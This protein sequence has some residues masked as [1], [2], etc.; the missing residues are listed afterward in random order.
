M[1]DQNQILRLLGTIRE[2]CSEI[3]SRQEELYELL[4]SY[5]DQVHDLKRTVVDKLAGLPRSPYIAGQLVPAPDLTEDGADEFGQLLAT[6]LHRYHPVDPLD[7]N[8]GPRDAVFEPRP[9]VEPDDIQLE[10]GEAR[11]RRGGGRRERRVMDTD[12]ERGPDRDI[13]PIDISD[14]AD[15]DGGKGRRNKRRRRRRGAPRP[16]QEK[17]TVETPRAES[18]GDAD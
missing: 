6:Y 5:K 15:D 12:L 14:D 3:R 7:D 11:P 17:E 4:I 13:E 16:K 18:S 10:A 2:E 8:S 9:P 1:S